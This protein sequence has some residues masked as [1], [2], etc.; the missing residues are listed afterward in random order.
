MGPPLPSSHP[1]PSPAPPPW[2]LELPL[3]LTT[4]PIF[5]ATGIPQALHSE[6]RLSWGP[7]EFDL[8]AGLRSDHGDAHLLLARTCGAQPSA[9]GHL[10]HSLPLLGRLGLPP[11]SAISLTARPGPRTSRGSLALRMGPC[12]L[13]GVLEQQAE[14]HSTWTLTTEPGCPLLEVRMAG[15]QSDWRG[16]FQ[17]PCQRE[18]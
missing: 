17:S 2:L 13:R 5:Q 1:G 16:S 8:A 15:Q 9:L 14:N 12:Q 3:N 18:A 6:G 10:T 4:F 11:G 7:C